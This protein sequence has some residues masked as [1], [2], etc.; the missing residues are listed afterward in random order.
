MLKR[1]RWL[2]ATAAVCTAGSAGAQTTG[3]SQQIERLEQQI[4]VLQRELR[5]I[6]ATVAKSESDAAKAES[7]ARAA[8]APVPVTKTP[9]PPPAAI[10]AMSAS[11]RPSIC[12]PDQQNC[13]ALTSRLQFDVGGY[14]YRP[15]TSKTSPQQLDDGVNA[16]RA[17]IG[18]L[19]TFM[20]DWNYALIY[21][22]GGSSDGFGGF[23][24][25]SLPGGGTSGIENA[26][27]SYSGFKPFVIEGGYM[28]LP[29][30]LD[31]A[32]SSNDIMFV[33]RASSSVIATN[34]AAGDFR[35]AGGMR[36]Y[37]DWI[38]AGGYLT[39]PTS[40]QMH[41]DTTTVTKSPQLPG[42]TT[43]GFSEQYGSVARLTLQALQGP[44]FSFHV[45]GDAE[46][47]FRPPV[48]PATS[49]APGTR[50][51]TL[52]DRPELR[53]DPTVMLT[54]G[55]MANVSRAQVYSAEAAAGWGPLFFQ[56]EYFWYNVDREFGLPSLR[57]NGGYAQAS[58]TLTGE[59]R[60]YIPASGA[61]G[62]I[63]PNNPVNIYGT[64]WGAWELAA[65]YSVVNLND[66]LGTAVGVAGGE[67]TIYTAG[68]NWYVNRN[69]RFMLNYLHGTVKK[70]ESATSTVNTGANFDAV[71]GRMQVAF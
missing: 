24:P 22:F 27:L 11:N 3:S 13:V 39:G 64:G 32:T 63:V 19:G 20:G 53:I 66:L 21:D 6:K 67:Q 29:Y 9:E 58:W 44:G 51:L 38:W 31:E 18:V 69:I 25:G 10:A 35:S 60:A 61:Y 42:I 59:S 28:D 15:A 33:E 12:T 71:A 52:S 7:S 49:T 14:N 4:Q 57:F 2:L 48:G 34:I 1:H 45:G 40:G 55:A 62:G 30:T 41:S 37:N 68:L 70:Q 26:W 46:F 43:F 5:Q 36:A 50:T 56:G 23:A 47:L 16:R 54:T 8:A 17:R 65:R